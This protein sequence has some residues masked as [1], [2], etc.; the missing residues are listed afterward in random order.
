MQQSSATSGLPKRS[1]AVQAFAAAKSRV[2]AA[3]TRAVK[4]F[5]VID[6][7][8]TVVGSTSWVGPVSPSARPPEGDVPC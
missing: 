2:V 4:T 1:H 8:F 6:D 3:A 5:C 7:L